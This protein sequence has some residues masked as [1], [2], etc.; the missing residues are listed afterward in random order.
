LSQSLVLLI[1]VAA[2]GSVFMQAGY[3]I[4]SSP[5]QKPIEKL[6]MKVTTKSQITNVKS[7]T[8]DE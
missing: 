8:I 2:N 7:G 5:E 4:T 6:K 3:F 1:P